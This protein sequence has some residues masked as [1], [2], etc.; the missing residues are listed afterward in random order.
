MNETKI[1]RRFTLQLLTAAPVMGAVLSACGGEK[2]L[3]CSDVTGLSDPEKTARQ[4]LNYTDKSPEAGKTC[5]N[6]NLYQAG[7]PDACG[8]CQVVKG[9]I[10]P[11]GYCASWVAKV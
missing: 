2:V 8:T 4:A 3:T 1:S 10:H 6:C 7:S 9:P 5:D 11:K